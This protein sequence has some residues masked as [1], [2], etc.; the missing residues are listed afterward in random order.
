[1]ASPQSVALPGRAERKLVG[2][3]SVEQRETPIPEGG[4]ESTLPEYF[5]RTKSCRKPPPA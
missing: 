1:M 2:R 3:D 5:E 4:L